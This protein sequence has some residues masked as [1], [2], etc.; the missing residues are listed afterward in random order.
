M[1]CLKREEVLEYFTVRLGSVYPVWDIHYEANLEI[2]L[3][4]ERGVENLLFNGRPGLFFYNNLH[5]SLDMGFVAARHILSGKTK[6]EKW[7]KD[8]QAFKEFQLV[9]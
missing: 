8:A 5:H 3:N 9:E 4:Y 7:D 6:A 1:A 2:L